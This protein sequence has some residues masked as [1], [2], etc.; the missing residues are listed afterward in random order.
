MPNKTS[1]IISSHYILSHWNSE[2]SFA[3]SFNISLWFFCYTALRIILAS[4]FLMLLIWNFH[5]FVRLI[6]TREISISKVG[7]SKCGPHLTSEHHKLYSKVTYNI[8]RNGAH[9]VGRNYTP[10]V[11]GG[12]DPFMVP[13]LLCWHYRVH[14]WWVLIRH[15]RIVKVL[16]ESSLFVLAVWKQT[17]A[18]SATKQWQILWEPSLEHPPIA[19]TYHIESH[20]WPQTKENETI[21]TF[22]KAQEH[23]FLPNSMRIVRY[24]MHNKNLHS[25]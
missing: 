2:I 5:Y 21:I 3:A 13:I 16:L 10:G 6:W 17:G 11:Y 4:F 8:R 23:I 22:S 19:L 20:F 24:L 7:N 18:T 14:I 12:Y 1:K 15:T 25:K 9:K